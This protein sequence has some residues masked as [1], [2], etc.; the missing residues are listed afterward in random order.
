ML[1]ID[2]VVVQNTF[3]NSVVE[4]CQQT[5]AQWQAHAAGIGCSFAPLAAN[6]API[7]Q[8]CPVTCANAGVQVA[9]CAPSAPALPPSSPPLPL[10]P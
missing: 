5:V 8:L 3:G 4:A 6:D 10:P 7:G 2:S 9:H 1:Q